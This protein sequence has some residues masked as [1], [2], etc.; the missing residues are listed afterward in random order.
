MLETFKYEHSFNVKESFIYINEDGPDSLPK[1]F[2]MCGENEFFHYFA[3]NQLIAVE[4]RRV[5]YEGRRGEAIIYYYEAG[6]YCRLNIIIKG[7]PIESIFFKVGCDHD[8]RYTKHNTMF[9][10]R[11]MCKK[12]GHKRGGVSVGF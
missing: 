3:T 12:C 10:N 7:L 8:Y 1:P 6:A 5:T 4:T 9:N 11:M 2:K